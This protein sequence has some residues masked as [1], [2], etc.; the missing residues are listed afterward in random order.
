V[1]G[2]GSSQEEVRKQEEEQ[3]KYEE[4][5]ER[6]AVTRLMMM[7]RNVLQGQIVGMYGRKPVATK[8]LKETATGI[9][10]EGKDLDR[11]MTAVNEK[12]AKLP[13][14]DRQDESPVE[15]VTPAMP[16][17]YL[18]LCLA[19]GAGA[20]IAV[21]LLLIVRRGRVNRRAGPNTTQKT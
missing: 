2:L 13:P 17:K 21:A 3:R 14:E 4:A 5:R 15:A 19:L 16:S 12:V 11:L 8:E 7:H 10:G 6:A 18:Y 1:I 20:V 9:L